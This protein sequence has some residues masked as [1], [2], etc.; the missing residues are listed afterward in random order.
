MRATVDHRMDL[1]VLTTGD[2]DRR[3]AEK[4][5]LVIARVRQFVIER[6]VLPGRPEKDAVALGAVDLRIGEH[7][8]RHPRIALFRPFE[9]R[10]ER[11]GHADLQGSER[12]RRCPDLPPGRQSYSIMKTPIIDDSGLAT[13]P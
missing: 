7:P 5:R 2:D 12:R 6:E 1:A 4:G 8:V 13:H 3:L 9:R 10:L 11:L